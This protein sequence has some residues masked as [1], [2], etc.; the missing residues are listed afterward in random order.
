MQYRNAQYTKDGRIDCEIEHPVYGWVPFTADKNDSEQH[1][2][3]I[4]G[5]I[6]SDGN[7]AAYTPPSP[8]TIEEIRAQTRIPRA[9][10]AIA[11]TKAG[12]ITEA[13][14]EEWAAGA[15]NPQWV[16]DAIEAAVA[17]GHIPQEERLEV[18][19]AVRT[20]DTIGRNDRLIPILADS[21]GLTPEQVDTLF[22]IN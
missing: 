5:Q 9:K 3:D 22:G 17:A 11:A 4:F 18:R 15:A 14:A 8:P 12:F 10:F 7:I 1:G 21:K 16:S 13:E 19:I 2:R 20:Q 6:V